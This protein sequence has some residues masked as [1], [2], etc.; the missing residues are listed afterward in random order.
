MIESA[1]PVVCRFAPS[2][3]GK[4]HLGGLKTLLYNFLFVSSMKGEL[5]L[6]IDDTDCSRLVGNSAKSLIST[7]KRLDLYPN[8]NHEGSINN[9]IFQSNR[10]LH[11]KNSSL[12]LVQ[13]GKAYF[14]DCPPKYSE[15]IAHQHRH[16]NHED[17]INAQV[18]QCGNMP[19]KSSPDFANSSN[20]KKFCIKFRLED[21]YNT[22]ED[23]LYGTITHPVHLIERDF[24]I[25][26]QNGF[27]TY[28]FASVIDDMSF[29][30]THIIRGMEWLNSVPKQQQLFK[31]FNCEIPAFMHLSLIFDENKK[32]MSKSNESLSVDT[33]LKKGYEPIVIFNYI[34]NLF[35][36][37]DH[38]DS[39]SK[40][41]YLDELIEKFDYRTIDN[42]NY[43]FDISK[44]NLLH[45]KAIERKI[46]KNLANILDESKDLISGR[47]K[48][49]I[50][51]DDKQL[52]LFISNNLPRCANLEDL[53]YNPTF[54]YF[55]SHEAKLDFTDNFHAIDFLKYYAKI[56][57][58]NQ[59]K[60][61]NI[62]YHL[63]KYLESNNVTNGLTIYTQSIRFAFTSKK[64]G[65]PL[66]E[67]M[68]YVN[69]EKFIREIE[70]L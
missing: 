12:K 17:D 62:L 36:G 66:V 7:I 20:E 63:K 70:N 4:L 51:M 65:P 69:I 46:T 38:A 32:K 11:Y 43:F 53:I 45:R 34:L 61:P 58:K 22:F 68:S 42:K 40:I 55:L 29:S 18:C 35:G 2:P 47:Y 37:I 60:I 28:Q 33:L 25:I 57:Q 56:F 16:Y 48:K 3:T 52:E 14:C 21:E 19:E 23:M 64:V 13:N 26:R 41:F 8:L 44:L 24:V 59:K 10:L 1:R 54:K 30:V 6:R 15:K 39:N 5:L 27:P 50:L 67:L 31:A 9:P 49:A